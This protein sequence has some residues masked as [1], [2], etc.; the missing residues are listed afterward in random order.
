MPIFANQQQHF[1]RMGSRI[2]FAPDAI[3]TTKY[4][5][6]DLGLLPAPVAPTFNNT[7]IDIR[8]PF[9]GNNIIGQDVSQI[10]EM[11][12][13]NTG[14]LSPQTMALLFLGDQPATFTQA[15][16]AATDVAQGS[17][18]IVGRSD[19]GGYHKIID[20]S[21]NPIYNLSAVSA[22]KYD[23]G[24][25]TLTL[26]TDYVVDSL[27]LGLIRLLPGG[28]F[29]EGQEVT[30][31]TVSYTPVA[32]TAAYRVITPHTRRVIEGDAF[33]FNRECNGAGYVRECRASLRPGDGT[34]FN[35]TELSTAGLMLTVLADTTQS[36]T[37]SFGKLRQYIGNVARNARV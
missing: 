33:I 28:E 6:I 29:T 14:N 16:T 12:S 26:G 13:F 3:G 5:I 25:T 1:T 9:F 17:S 24:P 30:D 7:N 2:L 23:T 31:L 37:N 11:Y 19:G 32:M 21:G 35:A 20:G 34:S 10:D 36:C 4:P 8:D 22:V 15:A 18:V 27:E